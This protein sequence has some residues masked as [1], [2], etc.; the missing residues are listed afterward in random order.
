LSR[1]SGGSPRI[2]FRD[3]CRLPP[4]IP[5]ALREE[6]PLSVDQNTESETARFVVK[7]REYGTPSTGSIEWR[8]GGPILVIGSRSGSAAQFV[9]VA[10]RSSPN[11]R[12]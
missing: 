6:V 3:D 2:A 1:G 9:K 12:A 5:A 7:G 10:G 8:F 11:L 4:C